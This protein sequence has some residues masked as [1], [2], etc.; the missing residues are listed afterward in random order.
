M[1]PCQFEPVPASLKKDPPL[2]KA[3]PISD[4][5][6]ASVILHLKKELKT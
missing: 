2:A 3:D 4:A 6:G 5:S 1:P